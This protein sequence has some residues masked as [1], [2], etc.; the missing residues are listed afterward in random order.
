MS[1]TGKQSPLGVNV[2]SS[3]LQNIG[4]CINPTNQ[5]YIGTSKANG[6]YTPGSLVNNTC[7]KPLTYAIYQAYNGNVAKTPTGTSTYDNLIAIG[8][9]IIPTL[10]NSKSPGY[11][12]DD[13]TGQWQGQATTGYSTA[14]DTGNGQSATWI[15]YNTQS[16]SISKYEWNKFLNYCL[17]FPVFHC[18]KPVRNILQLDWRRYSI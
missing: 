18:L 17:S 9:D 11:T 12:A 5:G 15:P 3:L 13:P 10:G 4:L 1:A 6:S 14:G 7:L 16:L 8:K 2:N